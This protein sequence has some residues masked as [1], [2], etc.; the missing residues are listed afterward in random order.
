MALI[1]PK[2]NQIRQAEIPGATVNDNAL[3]ALLQGTQIG[4]QAALQQQKNDSD[5][6]SLAQL[7]SIAKPGDTIKMGDVS[8]GKK[9]PTLQKQ[10]ELDRQERLGQVVTSRVTSDFEKQ[11]APIK[12]RIQA[13]ES[14]RNAVMSN[15]NLTLGQIKAML[16]KLEGETYRPTDV[17]RKMMLTP[18]AE[19]GMSQLKNFFGGDSVQASQSQIQALMD[20]TTSKHKLDSENL[21]NAADEV[22]KR[23]S[24]IL[25]KHRDININDLRSSLGATYKGSLNRTAATNLIRVRDKA[26]GKTGR[27]PANEFDSSKYEEIK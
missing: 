12:Q 4:S 9:D 10:A 11:A 1:Q 17:E 27:L 15:N 6:A 3:K 16:P 21:N 13:L 7:L 23:W 14:V 18:T 8:V 19:G 5:A 25:S 24:P 20:Y 2:P 22:L 26:S